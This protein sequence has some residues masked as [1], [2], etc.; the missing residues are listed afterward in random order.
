VYVYVSF[1]ECRVRGLTAVISFE[2][3]TEFKFLGLTTGQNDIQDE[4][5]SRLNLGNAC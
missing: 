1:P 2:N 3:V 4:I 5:K